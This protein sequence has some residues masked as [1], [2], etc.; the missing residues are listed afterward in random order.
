MHGSK[1]KP[2]SRP[3]QPGRRPRRSAVIRGQDRSRWTDFYHGVLRASWWQF[4]LGLGAIFIGINALFACLYLVAPNDIANER[5]GSFL[6]A[7]YFSVQTFGSIG[8][9]VLSPKSGY[10]NMLVTVESFVSLVN[11]AIATGL[12]FA[13]FS[14]PTARV[15]FSNVAVVTTFD[16][17]P[18]LMFRAVNQRGNQILDA[19]ISVSFAR[20]AVTREGIAMRR[21]EELKLVRARTPLFALSWTVMHTIDETSP[22][23]GATPA[24]LAAMQGELI[25]LLSGSDETLSEII[26]ARHGYAPEQIL[27]GRRF[28]DIIDFS[29]E[30]GRVIDLKRFHDTEPD[31]PAAG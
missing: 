5:P 3:L 7:F 10:A 30:G 26:Y 28:L 18:T 24:Q 29:V 17:R 20:Q 4:F 22:L 6:D 1:P 27:F 8:Y 16:G 12:V 2:P 19:G 11:L 25:A 13:R 14:R 15:M 9:G 21:F 31:A 23:Y